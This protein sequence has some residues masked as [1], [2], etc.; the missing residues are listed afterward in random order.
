[1]L[2]DKTVKDG[3][4][5]MP[6]PT[7][8]L[9]QPALDIELDEFHCTSLNVDQDEVLAGLILAQIK[10]ILNDDGLKSDYE[11]LL[12]AARAA[13][14]SL[15]GSARTKFLQGLISIFKDAGF[16]V[17]IDCEGDALEVRTVDPL[18]GFFSPDALPPPP[19]GW[20][21]PTEKYRQSPEAVRG[22]GLGIVPFLARVWG[23]VIAAMPEGLP[24]SWLRQIDDSAATGIDNHRRRHR[25]DPTKRALPANLNILLRPEIAEKDIATDAGRRALAASRAASRTSNAL[26][27]EARSI[28]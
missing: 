13:G 5:S 20:S 6:A 18:A 8:R 19:Q 22:S 12:D 1:M 3:A 14:N 25:S 16:S 2:G 9:S 28:G 17:T 4:K 23:P 7:T 21:W 27:R 24:L 11:E 10:G 15:T 26:R